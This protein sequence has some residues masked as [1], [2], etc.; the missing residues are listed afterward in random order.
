MT[1]DFYP[2]G[3]PGIGSFF[4]GLIK[5]AAGFIPGVG[6]IISAVLP[7]GAKQAPKAI[8][9][10]AG[11]AS[12][13]KTAIIKHPVISAAA[14][15]GAIGALAGGAVEEM[16]LAGAAC[17]RGF[18][19]C[20]SKKHGCKKGPCVRNRRMNSCNPRALRRAVR[21]LH[22]FARHYRKTVGFVTPHPKK[23]RMYFKSRKRR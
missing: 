20:K 8:T 1:G 23:G 18:H 6:P 19:P 11:A 15:A 4:G 5:K 2:R 13:I 3:D 14:G 10:A 7:G 21:R 17:P 12:S 9:A 22:S 16:H